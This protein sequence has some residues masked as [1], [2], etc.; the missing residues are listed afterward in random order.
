MIKRI[1]GK[2]GGDDIVKISGNTKLACLIGHPV[3]H[4]FSPYIQNYLAEKCE[5][6]MRYVCFDVKEEDVKAALEGVRTLGIVGS[7]VT[8]PHKVE[9]MKYLD[10]VDPNAALIGAVNCIKNQEGKLIGYN[11]DGV[12]FVK[13]VVDAGHCLEGKVAMVLRSEERRVGKEC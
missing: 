6:D 10:E 12:G 1:K 2:D 3:N 11:T 7:N 4:S 9:V 5:L 8:I 13:S